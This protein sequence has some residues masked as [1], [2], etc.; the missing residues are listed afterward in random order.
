MD[1]DTIDESQLAQL[2]SKIEAK[3]GQTRD[4]KRSNKFQAKGKRVAQSLQETGQ[5]SQRSQIRD[6]ADHN[7]RK[8]D[9]R[10]KVKLSLRERD[11]A[12]DISRDPKDVSGTD[13]PPGDR[14][15]QEVLQLGGTEDDLALVADAESTSE[16]EVE[17][18]AETQGKGGRKELRKDI[19]SFIQSLGIKEDRLQ[20]GPREEDPSSKAEASK[21]T[22]P[23]RMADDVKPAVRVVESFGMPAPSST[24]TKITNT[25]QPQL[26]CRPLS[27]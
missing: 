4:S 19:A 22:K 1:S 13:G 21:Q 14:L 27:L 26:V 24:R 2:T 3:L 7:G 12:S 9:A 18:V 8:R 10:G 5:P 20:E 17:A 11:D 23:K 6:A 25:P 16:L 15:L